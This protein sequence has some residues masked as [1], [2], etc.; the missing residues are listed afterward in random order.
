M[1]SRL[2]VVTPDL[3]PYAPYRL[4]SIEQE[5]R[6][7]APFDAL[8]MPMLDMTDLEV[9][10]PGHSEYLAAEDEVLLRA[11]DT[12][13]SSGVGGGSGV[14]SGGGGGGSREGAP[15]G[16]RSEVTWLRRTEYL[17]AETNRSRAGMHSGDVR[18]SA[19]KRPET[20]VESRED[21]LAAIQRSF[22]CRVDGEMLTHPHDPTLKAVAI[23]PILPSM[24]GP[25]TFAQCTF[26]ADPSQTIVDG[27]EVARGGEQRA[28]LKAMSNA[29]NV[30]DTFV[31]YYLPMEQHPLSE[32]GPE[33][34]FVYT[35]DYDIQRI[36]RHSAAPVYVLA[37]PEGDGEA[38]RYTPVAG[39]FQLK[40][41]RAKADQA[42]L[43][44][45]LRVRRIEE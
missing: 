43:R 34:R 18:R 4:T 36:D 15:K 44:H 14:G 39:H 26:D 37:V 42:Q 38:A 40:K 41:R 28:I 35:R 24:E 6:H 25:D 31:W 13:S 3:S 1:D 11:V 19:A 12:L 45:S 5:H 9:F 27:V 20:R 7:E 10:R 17:S 8:R 16:Q 32:E 2:V 22:E 23:Y 33:E 29:N 30:E 21:V